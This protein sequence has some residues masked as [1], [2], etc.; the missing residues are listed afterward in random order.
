VIDQQDVAA[1]GFTFSVLCAGP[2]DGRPVLLLHG[3]PQN[4]WCWRTQLEALGD[5]GYRAVAPDQRGYSA[6]ARP[7][8]VADYAAAHLV[9]DVVAL[10]DALDMGTFDLVGHDWGGMVSWLTAARHPDRVRSLTVISTPHPLALR[11]ALFS[12]DPE[13][14]SP[15][16]ST[17]AFRQA[18]VPETLLLGPDGSGSGLRKLLAA[19]GLPP[20][21]VDAYVVP[22]T[23]PGALTAAVNWFRAMTGDEVA[24]LPAVT[25]PTLYVWSTGDAALGRTAAEATAVYVSGPYTYVVLEDVSHWIPELAPDQLAQPLMTHLSAT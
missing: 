14:A 8:A 18:E 15:A 12:E 23:Q 5:A 11:L 17:D 24:H 6:G 7:A 21:A 13:Q 25:V 22:L 1:N 10:A 3:F 20:D 19:G 2:P 4:A 16:G 9:A